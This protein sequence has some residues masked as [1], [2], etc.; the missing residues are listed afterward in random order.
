MR[1]DRGAPSKSEA[2]HAE[3][4]TMGVSSASSA[5]PCSSAKAP[6]SVSR[7]VFELQLREQD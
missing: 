2:R 7:T 6:H 5:A 3:I 4:A 1:F